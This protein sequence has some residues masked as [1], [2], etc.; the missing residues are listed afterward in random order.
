MVYWWEGTSIKQLN[1]AIILGFRV[2][3]LRRVIFTSKIFINSILWT[4]R[5]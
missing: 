4:H 5:L 2:M 1:I 3:A